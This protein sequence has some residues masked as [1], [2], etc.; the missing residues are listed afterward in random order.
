MSVRVSES[1]TARNGRRRTV[2]MSLGTYV[3]GSVAACFTRGL[4]GLFLLP[5]V[6]AWWCLLAEL[7][8]CAELVL[9]TLTGLLAVAAVL[10]REARPGDITL[11]VT[12]WH[13]LVLGL[14]GQS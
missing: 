6:L 14:R 12:R 8:A 1:W 13:L 7:W 3:T 9:L 4:L 11:R 5:L 10:R 2:S